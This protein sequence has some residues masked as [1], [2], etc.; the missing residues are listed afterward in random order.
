LSAGD[1]VVFAGH[2]DGRLSVAR[3][4]YATALQFLELWTWRSSRLCASP[5]SEFRSFA[6]PISD[7]FEGI[8]GCQMTQ[9]TVGPMIPGPP[10]CRAVS[11]TA[12]S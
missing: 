11:S 4:R 5:K 12:T 9:W 6:A 3:Q 7:G 10:A 2:V 1:R 8:A